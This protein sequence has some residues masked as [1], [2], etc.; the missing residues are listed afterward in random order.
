VPALAPDLQV[1]TVSGVITDAVEALASHLE[2]GSGTS[3]ILQ[4]GR[5]AKPVQQG[6]WRHG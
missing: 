2:N 3:L 5:G 6:S 1:E 4:S